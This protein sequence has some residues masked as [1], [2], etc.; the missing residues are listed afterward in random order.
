MILVAIFFFFASDLIRG[1][2]TDYGVNFDE[3]SNFCG[4]APSYL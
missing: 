4:M 2:A 1:I 3:A